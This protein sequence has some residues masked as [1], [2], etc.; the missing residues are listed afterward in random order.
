M[1]EFVNVSRNGKILE[2]IFDKP[3]VNAVCAATSRELDWK[4]R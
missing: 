3:K 1:S 2:I 4:G